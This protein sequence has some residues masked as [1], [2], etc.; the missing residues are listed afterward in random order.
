[1]DFAGPYM[2]H[3]F[4][5]IQDMHSKWLDAHIMSTITSSKTIEV[6]HTVF[7]THGL[8]RKVVTDNG[9]SFVSD[10]FKSF[11]QGNGIHHVTSAPYHLSTNGLVERGVQTLKRGLKRTAGSSVREKLSRFLFDYRITPHSTTG[12][13]LSE[14]LMK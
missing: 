6:L 5:I 3:M 4:L 10:E 12:V 2:G 7:A 11:L 1:M 9:P 8:P 14:L 13:A